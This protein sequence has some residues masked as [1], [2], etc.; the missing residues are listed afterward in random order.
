MDI[1][2]TLTV[3][4]VNTVLHLIGQ[5]PTNSGLYPL[6]VKIKGQAEPQVPKQEEEETQPE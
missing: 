1:N 4:E 2:L 5:T 6:A 3:E